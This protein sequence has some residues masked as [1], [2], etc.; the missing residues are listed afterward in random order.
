MASVISSVYPTMKNA[1]MLHLS[2]NL[3]KWIPIYHYLSWGFFHDLKKCHYND[4]TIKKIK[5][6]LA[7]TL[8]FQ[9]TLFLVLSFLSLVFSSLTLTSFSE[10]WSRFPA[11]FPMMNHPGLQNLKYKQKKILLWKKIISKEILKQTD[12]FQIDQKTFLVQ[13]LLMLPYFDSSKWGYSKE[14]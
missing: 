12:F 11:W 6:N 13:Q 10:V 8:A 4:Y 2:W 5:I 7:R 3:V 9:N 1:E 14:S